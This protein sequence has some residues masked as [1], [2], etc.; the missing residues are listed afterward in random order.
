MRTNHKAVEYRKRHFLHTLSTLDVD[1]EVGCDISVGI[2][3]CY[4]M[5]GQGSDPGAG[6]VNPH[7]SRQTLRP[8]EPAVTRVLVLFLGIKSAGACRWSPNTPNAEV[9]EMV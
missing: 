7:P 2:A 3:S 6:R 5:D 9:K 4:G 8:T 1:A